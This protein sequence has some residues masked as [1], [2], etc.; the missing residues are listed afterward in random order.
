MSDLETLERPSTNGTPEL[1]PM[2]LTASTGAS[3][4]AA[5]GEA[6]GRATAERERFERVALELRERTGRRMA[7]V[8]AAIAGALAERDRLQ[9]EASEQR[10]LL[11]RVRGETAQTEAAIAAAVEQRE[12]CAR[13]A[14]EQRARVDQVLR[15]LSGYDALI[16]GIQAEHE[17]QAKNLEGVEARVTRER[18]DLDAGTASANA[19]R[20][21]LLRTAALHREERER[22]KA[23]IAKV[24]LTLEAAIEERE[25]LDRVGREIAQIEAAIGSVDRER[26]I[27]RGSVRGRT[28]LEI[29]HV[30]EALASAAAERARAVQDAAE[31]RRGTEREILTVDAAIR[32]IQDE[33]DERERARSEI[34]GVTAATPHQ[35]EPAANVRE[36]ERPSA[37]GAAGEAASLTGPLTE[38]VITS[39]NASAALEIG[40]TPFDGFIREYRDSTIAA[41]ATVSRWC[42]SLPIVLVAFLVAIAIAGLVEAVSGASLSASLLLIAGLLAIGLAVS[43]R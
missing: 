14:E 15:E 42:D 10:Q 3:I 39:A 22:A 20:E 40:A 21:R 32:A 37:P 5:A 6:L 35:D 43:R 2:S 33:R 26:A 34:D 38:S 31:T 7:T 19:D 28:A 9:R 36:T 29:E 27:E 12:R 17:R 16:G 4:L 41:L 25:R 13:A 30:D 8:A 11:E 18:A 23:E 24:Q 1:R